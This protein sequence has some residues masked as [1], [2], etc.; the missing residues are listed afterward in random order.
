MIW[1]VKGGWKV[2]KVGFLLFLLGAGGMDSPNMAVPAVM[3][4]SG[5]SI[6]AV[7][8]WRERRKG[9]YDKAGIDSKRHCGDLQYIR[10]QGLPDNKTA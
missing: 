5:L 4:L 8:A 6:L 9:Q 3:V 10:K 1:E 7:S 2:Q